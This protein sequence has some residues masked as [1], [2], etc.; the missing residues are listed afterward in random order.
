MLLR[1]WRALHNRTIEEHGLSEN[2][3]D[4]TCI[5]TS[6]TGME[7][8]PISNAMNQQALVDMATYQYEVP[9]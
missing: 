6:L 1:G 4:N 2:F 3:G 5:F 7:E 9:S 8:T